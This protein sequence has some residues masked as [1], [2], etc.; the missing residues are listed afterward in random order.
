MRRA[1]ALRAAFLFAGAARAAPCPAPGETR[2]VRIL[3]IDEHAE[4]VAA[5]GGPIRL[6]GVRVPRDREPA[7]REALDAWL[8]GRDATA[9]FLTADVDR[10]GRR[11]AR[12]T[13]PGAPEEPET[14]VE[15]RLIA[16]GLAQARPE[17]GAAA[18][19]KA[20]FAAEE[21]A[22]AAGRGLWADAAS[23]PV[24]ASDRDALR[25]R[26]GAWIVVEG[27]VLGVGETAN[28]LF[29]N[30]G[31]VRGVDFSAT[32]LKSRIKKLRDGGLDPAALRGVSTRV[33][34]WLDTRFGPRVE[35]VHPATIEITN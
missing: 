30:Y 31:P 22:R 14:S 15:T 11:V 3:R 16:A 23:R 20:L 8:V 10:W 32:V 35:I 34:G 5:D 17:P 1:R 12:L 26:D 2:P 9:A 27:R 19:L 21:R 6:F 4:P 18:C 29:L 28:R 33:R 13:T 25:G 24:A 7:A